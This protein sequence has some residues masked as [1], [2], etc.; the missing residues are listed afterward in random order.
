MMAPMRRMSLNVSGSVS[1]N[2]RMVMLRPARVPGRDA[3]KIGS[4]KFPW[5]RLP[6]TV[7]TLK[8]TS[9]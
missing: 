4:V 2:L 3:F 9:E 7:H 8:R 1:L 6:K 5:T